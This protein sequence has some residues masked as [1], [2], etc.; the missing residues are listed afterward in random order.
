MSEIR[1][2]TRNR[3]RLRHVLYFL[4]IGSSA[5]AVGKEPVMPPLSW[6]S[7]FG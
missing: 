6:R 4:A 7:N 1:R 2:V 5:L 3:M